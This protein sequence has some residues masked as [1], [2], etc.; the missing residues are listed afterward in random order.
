MMGIEQE[1]ADCCDSRI[2]GSVLTCMGVPT[3]TLVTFYD[4]SPDRK[5]SLS[6]FLVLAAAE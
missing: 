4:S 6:A 1:E 2:P 3:A 5:N